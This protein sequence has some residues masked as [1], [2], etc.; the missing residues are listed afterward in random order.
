ML[1]DGDNPSIESASIFVLGV[2]LDVMS[3]Q[4]YLAP[5]KQVDRPLKRIIQMNQIRAVIFDAYGTLFNLNRLFKPAEYLIGNRHNEVLTRWRTLQ[6]EYAWLSAL[7][8]RYQDFNVLT[9]AAFTDALASVNM[10]DPHLVDVLMAGFSQVEAFPDVEPVLQ[11]L[12]GSG[13]K[14]AVLSNG[15]P[16]MLLSAARS[17]R[18]LFLLDQLISVDAAKTYKPA[19]AAYRLGAEAFTVPPSEIAFVSSN[20]WDVIGADAFGFQAIWLNRAKM[21]WPVN[22]QLITKQISDFSSI[23]DILGGA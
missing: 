10:N 15:T 22:G 16:D 11:V 18:L 9:R 5:I 3:K 1:L 17:A 6:L 23:L 13:F 14:C 20:W 2:F 8:N 21:P 12:K 19:P 7:Q 4:S